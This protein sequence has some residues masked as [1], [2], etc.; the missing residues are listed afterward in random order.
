M[1]KTLQKET[2]EN[3]HQANV[4]LWI[5]VDTSTVWW[6]TWPSGQGLCPK[7][8]QL[9]DHGCIKVPQMV[10]IIQGNLSS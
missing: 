3:Y 10:Q 2:K 7:T 6:P 1:F 4:V 8:L 9:N 5:E